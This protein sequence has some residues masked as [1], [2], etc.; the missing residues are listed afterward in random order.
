MERKY[1]YETHLHTAGVSACGASTGTEMARFMKSSGFDGI[2]VTD[3]FFNGNSGIPRDLPWNERVERYCGGYEE[4]KKEGERIGLDVF[5]GIEWNFAGDEYLLYGIDKEWLLKY[6]DMLSWSHERLFAEINA[7]NGLMVQAHPFRD[8]GYIT[9]IH[10]HP[11]HVHAAE[12]ANSGNDPEFDSLAYAY[13]KHYDLP[14]T[15][16][17]DIH[18][19]SEPGRGFRGVILPEKITGPADYVRLIKGRK[20]ELFAKDSDFLP[21]RREWLSP[22]PTT[23]TEADGV[24]KTA[25]LEF[26]FH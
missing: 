7:V 16:G 21:P 3:H 22:K 4:A 12:V 13:A 20:Q 6:P 11:A 23:L 14:M 8:R 25:E 18:R 26:L 24:E 1:L 15:A 5:F 17:S 10:L 2:F 9:G 19:D